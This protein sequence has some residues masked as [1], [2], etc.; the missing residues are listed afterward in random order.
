MTDE[1]VK[2][3]RFLTIDQV[4]QELNVGEP[5]VRTLL[6]TGELRGIQIGGRGL[7]RIGAKDF[8]AYVE[9]AYRRTAEK[10]SAGDLDLEVS[11]G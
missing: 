4:A 2:S 10:I 6:K 7:W 5:V 9:E 3:P 11:E 1:P 8:E